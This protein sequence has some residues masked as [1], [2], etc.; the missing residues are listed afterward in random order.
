MKRKIGGLAASSRSDGQLPD[1]MYLV[2][3]ERMA[4]RWE[5][6]KPFYSVRLLVVEPKP[7]QGADIAGRLYCTP[8][9]LWK[10]SWF[11]RDFGYDQELLGR[12]EIDDRAVVGLRGV[13]KVTHTA[14]NGRTYQNL[15][16]F[17][18]AGEWSELATDSLPFEDGDQ[19][20]A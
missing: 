1:G 15:E 5:K 4:Y 10:L 20:V 14:V 19:E 18:P 3:I 11:L 17:A 12:D 6:H 2:R 9:A 16:A 7:L 13:I 8:K